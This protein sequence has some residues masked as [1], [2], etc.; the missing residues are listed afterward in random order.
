MS[1][2]S[3]LSCTAE[4][5]FTGILIN[6]KLMLPDHIALMIVFYSERENFMPEEV[7]LVISRL[8]D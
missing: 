7:D 3:E 6:P 5:I 4:N 1:R 8:A 2:S